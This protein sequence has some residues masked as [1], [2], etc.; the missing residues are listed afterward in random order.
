MP[1]GQGR[2][3]KLLSAGFIEEAHCTTWL[4][5]MVLVKNANDKWQMCFDYTDLNK[6]CPRDAYPLPNIVRLVDGVAGNKVLNFLDA[7]SG[8]NQIPM[9]AFDMN[10]TAFITDDANYFYKV[11]P[12]GLKNAGATYQRLMDKVFSHLMGKCVEVYIDDMVVKSPS[13]HQHAQDLSAVFSAL[14]QYNVCLYPYKCVF[15]VDRNKF[16][17]FMLTQRSIEANPKKCNAI[18]EMRSP[19]NVKEVQ[20][21]I[22][23]LSAIS[24][25]LPKLAEQTQPIIQ[26]LR[27]SAKFTWNDDC[28]QIFQK[29]KSPSPHHPSS[30]NRILINPYW[31]TLPPQIT[32]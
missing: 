22:G 18:I 7:Y 31:S 2:G 8:Y 13:H 19:T 28:E 6:A 27:K 4:S 12:Y 17:R 9:A 23:H 15:G 21:L 20:C 10:K 11:K 25:F 26:L 16:L 29:L 3:R 14:R 30:I 5:N 1:S 24:R 32:P